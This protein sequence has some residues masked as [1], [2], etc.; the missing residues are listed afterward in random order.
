MNTYKVEYEYYKV[1]METPWCLVSGES[2]VVAATEDEARQALVSD[3]K[4]RG[5]DSLSI[6][7]LDRL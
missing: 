1:T 6:T 3:A 2:E 4:M 5:I 7:K